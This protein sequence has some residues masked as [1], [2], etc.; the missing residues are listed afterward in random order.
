MLYEHFF[1]PCSNE[2]NSDK[3]ISFMNNEFQRIFIENIKEEKENQT[4]ILNTLK[5]K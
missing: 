1:S 5:K 3:N 4:Q 2:H